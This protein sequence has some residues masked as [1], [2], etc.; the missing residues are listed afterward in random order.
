MSREIKF[1]AWDKELE[2]WID[3]DRFQ[4]YP[5]TGIE[6]WYYPADGGETMN[7]E[8]IILEQYTGLKDKNGKEI[9]EGDLIKYM[10][11]TKVKTGI[12]GKVISPWWKITKI[13]YEPPSF[14]EIIINQE[15]CFFGDLPHK[16]NINMF[17]LHCSEVIGNIHE[18]PEILK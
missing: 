18:S 16:Q 15:N 8:D 1:R 5:Q 12:Y 14:C 11:E 2:K 13:I 3:E 4:I 9:Y 10:G 6:A 17:A 7:K